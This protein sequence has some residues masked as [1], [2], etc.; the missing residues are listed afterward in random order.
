MYGYYINMDISRIILVPVYCY[1]ILTSKKKK[2]KCWISDTSTS[3]KKIKNPSET[4]KDFD[5]K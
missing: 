5:C 4:Y 1:C 2:E 3:I